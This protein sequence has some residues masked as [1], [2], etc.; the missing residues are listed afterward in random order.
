MLKYAYFSIL[1]MMYNI[2]RPCEHLWGRS[3]RIWKGLTSYFHLTKLIKWSLKYIKWLSSIKVVTNDDFGV[4][5]WVT[6][7]WEILKWN[8]SDHLISLLKWKCEVWAFFLRV[9]RSDLCSRH[10]NMNWWK[11]FIKYCKNDKNSFILKPKVTK[12][13]KSFY[14]LV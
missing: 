14:I 4:I 5:L 10:F 8:L 3:I 11:K 12:S 9:G 2:P 6:S 1:F 7:N 13:I